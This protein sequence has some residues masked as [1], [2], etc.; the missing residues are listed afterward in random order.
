MKILTSFQFQLMCKNTP[1]FESCSLQW[2]ESICSSGCSGCRWRIWPQVGF[3]TE[4][5]RPE[6]V[7]RWL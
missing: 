5:E 6:L 7:S 4:A 1:K 3:I 2:L